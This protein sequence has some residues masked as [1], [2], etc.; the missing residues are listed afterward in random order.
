MDKYDEALTMCLKAI[1]SDTA[2]GN[3]NTKHLSKAY[4]ELGYVY[5]KL[6]NYQKAAEA[7]AEVGN[8]NPK[9]YRSFNA[10]GV[11]LEKIDKSDEAIQAYKNAVEIKPNYYQAYARL[12]ALYNKMGQ[13]QNGLD[14]ALNS[15]KHRKNYALAA[16]E[17]GTAYKNLSQF[18]NAITYFQMAAKDRAWAQS[19][20]WEIDMIK[21]KMK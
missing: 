14:A 11:A 16:F 4:Y 19:A 13:Y 12:A 21:R 3:A 20:N 7:F 10:Q 15:L 5:N 18:T 9:H 6:K 2:S 17:A 1:E 8:Y